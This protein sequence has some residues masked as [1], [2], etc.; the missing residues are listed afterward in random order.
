[1]AAAIDVLLRDRTLAR[2][3]ARAA[4]AYVVGRYDWDAIAARLTTCYHEALSWPRASSDDPTADR[5]AAAPRRQERTWQT[6]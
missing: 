1:M 5:D 2:E 6:H 4:R 3:I